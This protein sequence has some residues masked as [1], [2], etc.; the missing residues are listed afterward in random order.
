MIAEVMIDIDDAFNSLHYIEQVECV[1]LD[2]LLTQ[3]RYGK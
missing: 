3:K 2:K 1:S